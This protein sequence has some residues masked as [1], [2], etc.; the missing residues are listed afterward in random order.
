MEASEP[1]S[2]CSVPWSW[3]SLLVP[4]HHPVNDR[5]WRVRRKFPVF[6][7]CEQGDIPGR[8]EPEASPPKMTEGVCCLKQRFS[9]ARVGRVPRGPSDRD[10][11]GPPP[12]DAYPSDCQ[13]YSHSSKSLHAAT[14]SLRWHLDTTSGGR[15]CK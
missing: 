5:G 13:S 9:E 14:D 8:F 4:S 2:P 15:F 1:G 7:L 11:R 12:T 10:P 3:S 6:L